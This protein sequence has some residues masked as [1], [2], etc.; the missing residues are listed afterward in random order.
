MAFTDRIPQ[1][2]KMM[3]AL[4]SLPWKLLN[5]KKFMEDVNIV[6]LGKTGH[7]KSATGNT[8][9]GRDTFESLATPSSTTRMIEK[10][11]S[12]YNNTRIRVFDTPGPF[13]TIFNIESNYFDIEATCENMNMLMRGCSEAGVSAFFFVFSIMARYTR[14]EIQT[15]SIL[16]NIF[17]PDVILR[18][19]ALIF[20]HGDNF[21]QNFSTWIETQQ[22]PIRELLNKFNGKVLLITNKPGL[23]RA[24]SNAR[25]NMIE[26]AKQ[27]RQNNGINYNCS[28][29]YAR[30]SRS[31]EL[32][33][34]SANVEV[35]KKELR[36]KI[37]KLNDAIEEH[38][39][40]SKTEETEFV[41]RMSILRAEIV[42]ES[43]GT[44]KLNLLIDQL[45]QLRVDMKTKV[46][47]CSIV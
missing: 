41:L 5:L 37:N 18:F 39:T 17:G 20:T 34:F 13:E 16:E 45:D 1:F 15:I 2:Y 30:A 25:V 27:I 28:V 4:A 44:D 35:I 21:E 31:R 24:R 9:L 29:D 32:L 12:L 19:G 22:G 38:D 40:I 10:S 14:E 6:L 42:R 23:G 43:K 26:M 8:I 47:K 46:R 33:V 11:S 7:G 3:M 36:T